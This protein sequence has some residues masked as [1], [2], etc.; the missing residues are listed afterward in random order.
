[1][2]RKTFILGSVAATAVLSVPLVFYRPRHVTDHP[3][4]VP[5]VLGRLCDETTLHEIGSA[6]R[7]SARSELTM[8]Q[9]TAALLTTPDGKLVPQ[10]DERTIASL[11]EKKVHDDFAAQRILTLCGWIVSTTEARQCALFSLTLAIH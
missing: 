2:N 8:E 6:Y 4:L 10:S 1:M 11:M 9:L 7:T 5:S 3:L